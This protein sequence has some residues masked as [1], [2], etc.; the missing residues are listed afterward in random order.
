MGYLILVLITRVFL[1]ILKKTQNS[2]TELY[3]KKSI[4]YLEYKHPDKNQLMTLLIREL[5]LNSI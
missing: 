3:C 2:M 5:Y 4:I 1:Y